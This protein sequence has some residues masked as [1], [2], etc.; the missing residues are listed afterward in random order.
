MWVNRLKTYV[1]YKV[2][3]EIFSKSQNNEHTVNLKKAL[4]PV[5]QPCDLNS[6]NAWCWQVH[7]QNLLHSFKETVAWDFYPLVL[8]IN[9]SHLGLCLLHKIFLEFCFEFAE[10][11]EFKIRTALW[12]TAGNPILFANSRNLKLVWR[13]PSLVLFIYIHFLASLSL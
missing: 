13:R 11:F 6:I 8:F 3:L 2:A 4:Y 12:A 10:L 1:F 7:I 9:R 5:V